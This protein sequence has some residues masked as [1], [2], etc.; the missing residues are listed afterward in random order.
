MP[1][2]FNKKTKIMKK[3]FLIAL[4]IITS[5]V[6]N[7]QFSQISNIYPANITEG[8][9]FGSAVAID[10]DFM[11]VGAYYYNPISTSPGTGSVYM[12]N[13]NGTNWEY[14]SQIIPTLSPY[15]GD[16]FGNAV[17]ISGSNM[18]VGAWNGSTDGDHNPGAVTF[19]H[20]DGT[21]WTDESKWVCGINDY[22][23]GYGTDVDIYGDYAIVG[24]P[25]VD[26][27]HGRAYVYYKNAG[28]WEMQQNLVHS[29]T[30]QDHFGS[31]VAIGNYIAFIGAKDEN[32]V[33][34]YT[35]DGSNWNNTTTLTPST[36]G[37][38]FGNSISYDGTNLIVGD[39]G[40]NSAII[41]TFDGTNWNQQ[42]ITA[43][44]GVS[45]DHFGC[46]VSIDGNYAIVGAWA[47]NSMTGAA[48]I[49]EYNGTSWSQSQK[50]TASNG[51]S[52]DRFGHSVAILNNTAVVGAYYDNPSGMG[53]YAGSAYIYQAPPPPA[54]II[55]Q[56]PQNSLVCYGSSAS[57]SIIASDATSYQWK[58]NGV[59]IADTG[60]YSGTNTA[61]LSISETNNFY[62]GNYLCVASNSNGSTSSNSATLTLEQPVNADF[63]ISPRVTIFPNSNIDF[64]NLSDNDLTSYSWDFGD[65]TTIEDN[66]FVQNY[67]HYYDNWGIYFITLSVEGFACTDSYTDSVIIGMPDPILV[68]STIDD[69]TCGEGINFYAYIVYAESYQWYYNYQAIIDTGLFSGVTTNHLIISNPSSLYE[70]DYYC[71]GSNDSGFVSTDTA[72]LY[73]GTPV[74]ANFTA[75]PLITHLPNSTIDIENTSSTDADVYAWDFDDGS[76]YVSYNYEPNLSHT[77][78]YA[79]LFSITLSVYNEYC[80]DQDT[81]EVTVLNEININDISNNLII[82]PNPVADYFSI[83]GLSGNT[84]IEIYSTDGKLLVAK[85][86]EAN[87]KIYISDLKSGLY[88]VVLY[89]ADKQYNFKLL[90]M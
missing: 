5:F 18:I 37:V 70:G 7:A 22:D 12:W 19:Y 1:S 67:S 26:N 47:K 20:Y 10:G 48:Y 61:N 90:K 4:L 50:I 51:N 3:N 24:A 29:S 64:E 76:T 35:Y 78:E 83:I 23:L 74:I 79:G 89:D 86:I 31:S 44:D 38:S 40:D 85:K 69:T 11:A 66:V 81:V 42:K 80:E 72:H 68:G 77:F 15:N 57:F 75:T 25:G 54:P 49:F 71:I 65:G 2:F 32:K 53:N 41:F 46:N 14:H 63:S 84:D 87:Q 43:S 17:A 45:T 13:F 52:N 39:E 34:V 27:N 73:I 56:Q 21:S 8:D 58:L 59:N 16:Q 55:T 36:A 88:V 60:Y 30:T 6:S 62:A 28:T 82:N 9:E 33:Y